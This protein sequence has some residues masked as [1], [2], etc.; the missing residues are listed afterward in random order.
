MSINTNRRRIL[1]G[2]LSMPLIFTFTKKYT[3]ISTLNERAARRL[4]NL[5]SDREA[6]AAIGMEFLSSSTRH[7]DKDDLVQVLHPDAK[8]ISDDKLLAKLLLDSQQEDFKAGRT[9]T[10]QG[11]TLS[12][13]EAR[14]CALV[15][16]SRHAFFVGFTFDL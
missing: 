4:V 10:L 9:I 16:L 5:F 6:T 11:W 14:L 15:A 12:L 13:T 1:F 8:S 3:A 2:L 7:Y